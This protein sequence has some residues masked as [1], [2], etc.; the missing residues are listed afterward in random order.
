MKFDIIN[1]FH[2]ISQK[3]FYLKM[4]YYS[5][6]DCYASSHMEIYQQE[7]LKKNVKNKTQNDIQSAPSIGIK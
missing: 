7:N 2:L 5:D 1:L 6:C 4:S 3:S